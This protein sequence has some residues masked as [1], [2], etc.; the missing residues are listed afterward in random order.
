[1]WTLLIGIYRICICRYS[2]LSSCA[3]APVLRG[4]CTKGKGGLSTPHGWCAE[5]GG[6]GVAVAR[7]FGP[8][9]PEGGLDVSGVAVV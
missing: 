5:S 8:G 6:R 1:M 9:Q 7:M 3:N 2:D 4:T